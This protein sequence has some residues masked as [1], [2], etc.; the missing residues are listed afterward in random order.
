[1]SLRT[2]R[3]KDDGSHALCDEALQFRLY[4][5]GPSTMYAFDLPSERIGGRPCVDRLDDVLEQLFR[6]AR[7][8]FWRDRIL[9]QWL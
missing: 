9:A 4:I 1:M 6:P 5:R 3:G 2:P 8:F 7:D